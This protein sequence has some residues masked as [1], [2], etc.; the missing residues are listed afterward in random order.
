MNARILLKDIA[1][2]NP[3]TPIRDHGPIPFVDMGSIQPGTRLVR[4]STF[5]EKATGARFKSGDTLFARITPCLENGKIAQFQSDTNITCCGSTEFIVLRPR[6]G[7]TDPAFLYYLAT[8]DDLRD[9]A[10]A[11]MAG[12][13]GRQRV[14]LEAFKEIDVPFPSIESQ[15][16]V[17]T[18][19]SA[20]DDLIENNNRRIKLL[21]EMTQ[22]IYREWFIDFRYPGHEGVPLVESELG[23]I[24]NGWSIRRLGDEVEL[25]YGKALKSGSRRPGG[26]AVFGSGGLIGTHDEALGDGPTVIVGRKGNVGAVYWSDGSFFAIDTTYWVRSELPMTY[27]FYALRDA[28][29]LDSHAAV[30]GLSRE[31]AYSLLF[32][33]PNADV[34]DQFDSMIRQTFS[35]RRHLDETNTNLR[36][37]R[38]LLLPR[39]ISGEIDVADLDIAPT[40]TAA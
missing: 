1:I 8:S 17:A 4:A 39:L 32:I 10:I 6:D 40:E 9:R 23:S 18:V 20:Y 26:V 5:R 28:E 3:P 30:P 25:V 13:S 33:R 2:V 24:P 29:F 35:L 21:E 7:I 37:S 36:A 38:D 34:L 11:T 27:C 16:K 19:L 14:A 15:R 22:R 12:A 31:Q